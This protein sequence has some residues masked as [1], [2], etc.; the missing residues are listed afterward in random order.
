MLHWQTNSHMHEI[1]FRNVSFTVQVQR[2]EHGD[3]HG[4]AA[5][6][7]DGAYKD[8]DG[9]WRRVKGGH[10]QPVDADT[11]AAL[12]AAVDSEKVRNSICFPCWGAI[13]VFV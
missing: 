12:D 8:A 10:W 4:A 6:L 7:P 9:A 13:P 11:A 1:T 3:E 5:G 2:Q